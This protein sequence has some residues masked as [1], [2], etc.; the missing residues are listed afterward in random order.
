[1]VPSVSFAWFL[2]CRFICISLSSRSFVDAP[3]ASKASYNW[4]L[5]FS[6]LASRHSRA[7]PSK[8]KIMSQVPP[9]ITNHVLIYLYQIF[10]QP[11][12]NHLASSAWGVLLQHRLCSTSSY[13]FLWWKNHD[14]WPTIYSDLIPIIEKIVESIWVHQKEYGFNQSGERISACLKITVYALCK[15]ENREFHQWIMTRMGILMCLKNCVPS[16]F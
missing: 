6:K 13:L 12:Y 15:H 10:G 4:F 7:P 16:N 9:Q 2:S 8:L 3:S 14:A 1:L 5:L 11:S